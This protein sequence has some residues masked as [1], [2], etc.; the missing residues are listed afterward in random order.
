MS[1]TENQPLEI[2]K[3]QNTPKNDIKEI[4][5]PIRFNTLKQ[6]KIGPWD[7]K[8]EEILLNWVKEK[9]PCGW[10]KC[11]KR[12]KYRTGKQC[13]EHWN[14]SLNDS[15]K[16]GQWTSEENLLILKLYDKFKSWKKIL[17]VFPGRA[18]N[19]I[20]NRFYIQL[21]KIWLKNPKN[22]KKE[23]VSKIRLESLIL[24]FDEALKAAEDDY[25]EENKNVKKENFNNYLRE[26]EK[27]VEDTKK[28]NYI[29][30]TSLREKTLEFKEDENLD[31]D[32]DSISMEDDE[33]EMKKK[34]Q[35]ME[36]KLSDINKPNSKI[37][38]VESK[39]ISFKNKEV[40][41]TFLGKKS[42]KIKKEE[43][44]H[45]SCERKVKKKEPKSKSP[46]NKKNVSKKKITK[47]SNSKLDINNK[48][49]FEKPY[50]V[51]E[52]RPSN[53]NIQSRNSKYN[54]FNSFY[55]VNLNS[56]N[57]L[58]AKQSFL[59]KPSYLE[60]SSFIQ[61]PSNLEKSGF[62]RGPSFRENY[63]FLEGPCLNTRQSQRGF[64]LFA[65]S[66]YLGDY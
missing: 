57:S 19:S 38:K 46:Q 4:N 37:K 40:E 50:D 25:Y 3:G 13:R 16:K 34:I 20:K 8:E 60:K 36:S 33:D 63:S 55:G 7:E 52:S 22:D 2:V 1:S 39:S 65:K 56:K 42:K 32:R 15:L 30:I 53:K 54:N 10:T 43:S 27:L 31:N 6:I 62:I 23:H 14:N 41:N 35:R 26:I 21:R 28:G 59:Q 24:C 18:E 29:D 45:F 5:V 44:P 58:F 47:N 64:N 11:A 61:K 17:P 9:G 49:N 48:N 66:S 51:F 12:I